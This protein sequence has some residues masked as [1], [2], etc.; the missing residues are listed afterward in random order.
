MK[1]LSL[2]KMFYDNDHFY[3][4]F[5][6]HRRLRAQSPVPADINTSTLKETQA[7]HFASVIVSILININY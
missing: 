1:N 3:V 4:V 7:L 6:F 5:R 2:I